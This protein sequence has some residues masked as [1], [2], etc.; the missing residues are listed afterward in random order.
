MST[1]LKE[2]LKDINMGVAS[3]NVKGV[4]DGRCRFDQVK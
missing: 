3:T 1:V 2:I 4:E